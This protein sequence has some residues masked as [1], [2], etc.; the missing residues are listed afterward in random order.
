MTSTRAITSFARARTLAVVAALMAACN[1]PRAT[2]DSA[3]HLVVRHG[4]SR[5]TSD[6]FPGNFTGS[7]SVTPIFA[8]T[9]H[10][11]AT[12]ASVSF[13]PNARTAWH[14]H[15]GGQTLFVT[16]GTGWVQESGGPRLEVK[17]GD[18]IWTPPGVKHWHGATSS[19]PMTHVAIQAVVSGKN[20][21]W[22]E[23]VTDGGYA[24]RERD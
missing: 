24:Q 2:A 3:Q 14:T 1:S 20:V 7:A 12:G 10:L 8:A 6:V 17:P 11:T 13:E 19:S 16:S 21:T 15:P 23:P 5:S 4:E 18:V 9:E 22:M